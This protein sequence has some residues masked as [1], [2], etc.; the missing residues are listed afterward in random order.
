MTP[1]AAMS[2]ED[3]DISLVLAH[4]HLRTG[5]LGL[6]RAELEALAGAGALDDEGLQDLAEVRWRTGDLTGAGEAATAYL[7]DGQPRTL[8][9]VIAAEA[10]AALG[11]PGE[12]RTLAGRALES[13]DGPLDA[14]FAGIPRSSVWPADT[15][16]ARESGA[17]APS[18]GVGSRASEPP[19]IPDPMTELE[20][21]R[22][23]VRGG[24]V[25]AGAVHLS[26]AMRLSPALAPAVL[27]ALG[28]Q[29][30][31][32]VEIVRGDAYR[33]VG[34]EVEARRSFATA[35]IAA[36]GTPSGRDRR[37]ATD[38]TKGSTQQEER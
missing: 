29:S 32:I 33:L 21:G 11:R 5:S 35:A 3:R 25:A 9:L 28:T 10:S 27:D 30:G 26:V 13:A 19:A 36:R 2:N 34:R 37:R 1:P 20:A 22:T 12:A 18:P 14:I 6:A 15:G 16:A 7:A 38:A 24:D 31:A 4:V 23:A 8:P 17:T